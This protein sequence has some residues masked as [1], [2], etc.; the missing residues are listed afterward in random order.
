MRLKKRSL[1]ENKRKAE[2]DHEP[3]DVDERSHER[4]RCARWIEANSLQN[5]GE[6]RA[7]ERPKGNK[8]TRA[9]PTVHATS[10]EVGSEPRPVNADFSD[11]ASSR[12]A[13][14]SDQDLDC[15]R[16]AI[17]T[18]TSKL[19]GRCPLWVISGHRRADRGCPLYSRQQTCS[20]CKSMSAKC[21][22]RTR[23]CFE[24]TQK[25]PTIVTEITLD[26]ARNRGRTCLARPTRC[27]SS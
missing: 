2:I 18:N 8:P 27:H 4:C 3:R 11:A 23:G 22:K 19:N 24:L 25:V 16:R 5:E 13:R 10:R 21:Q 26:F 12:T 1:Q 17:R 20:A 6:H 14:S 9:A 7:R 15:C